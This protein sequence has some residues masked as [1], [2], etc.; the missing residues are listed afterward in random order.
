VVLT[1]E[2]NP[3]GRAAAWNPVLRAKLATEPAGMVR[4]EF[5]P[6]YQL[7]GG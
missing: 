4:I 6:P 2:D 1:F 5:Q 7:K 3:D